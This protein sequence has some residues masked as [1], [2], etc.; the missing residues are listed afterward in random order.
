MGLIDISPIGDRTMPLRYKPQLPKGWQ[1]PM[2]EVFDKRKQ[3]EISMGRYVDESG[4][5][6]DEYEEMQK[7]TDDLVANHNLHNEPSKFGAMNSCRIVVSWKIK[8]EQQRKLGFL[9]FREAQEQY[10]AVKACE[11]IVEWLKLSFVD[12]DDQVMDYYTL[13]S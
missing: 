10:E 7:Y 12:C 3:Q 8:E 9:S 4:A 6:I 5:L 1:H 11:G 13:R 2:K